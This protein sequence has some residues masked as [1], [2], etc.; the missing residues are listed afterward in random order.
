MR[1]ASA[2]ATRLRCRSRKR[3][4]ELEAAESWQ[5]PAL[6]QQVEKPRST[7]ADRVAGYEAE[8]SRLGAI[9]LDDPRRPAAHLAHQASGDALR[10]QLAA[11]AARD[12]LVRRLDAADLVADRPF[13]EAMSEVSVDRLAVAALSAAAE[14]RR[15]VI[16]TERIQAEMIAEDR[17][18]AL[19]AD[20]LL[21]V[22]AAG[23]DL[24]GVRELVSRRGVDLGE[25]ALALVPASDF[26]A[27]HAPAI[28]A[29]LDRE[30]V[31]SGFKDLPSY[32][33]SWRRGRPASAS[34]HD[35]E[36]AIVE[37]VVGAV[38]VE[39]DRDGRDLRGA[40]RMWERAADRAAVRE[41]SGALERG[42]I[43]LAVQRVATPEQQLHLELGVD[44]DVDAGHES[45]QE[46]GVM[47]VSD[48]D[49][50]AERLAEVRAKGRHL[51]RLRVA[52]RRDAAHERAAVAADAE[53]EAERATGQDPLATPPLSSADTRTVLIAEQAALE[54]GRPAL[55]AEREVDDGVEMEF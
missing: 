36:Q 2:R 1:R 53:R 40:Q 12:L 48:D 29:R 6:R 38:I 30:I 25:V 21:A 54:L 45:E 19:R 13:I 41:W 32:V 17:H 35:T 18:A 8:A 5:Q 14:D 22:T 46:V 7:V 55:V 15:A 39:A 23:H 26:Y 3:L 42:D 37:H 16:V 47:A 43:E 34:L 27:R 33:A 49:G 51:G 24:G 50:T 4:E 44:R 10:E 9:P 31:A 28:V 20:V 11:E 52:E